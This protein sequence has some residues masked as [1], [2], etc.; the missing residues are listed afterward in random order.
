MY[1]RYGNYI[2]VP[3]FYLGN[4]NYAHIVSADGTGI[5]CKKGQTVAISFD[6][7]LADPLM[8]GNSEKAILTIITVSMPI[9]GTISWGS[10]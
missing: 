1:V 10:N 2:T 7:Y 6:Q 5:R 4:G 3:S 9:S 8:E